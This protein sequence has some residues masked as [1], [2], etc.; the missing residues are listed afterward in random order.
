MVMVGNAGIKQVS[1]GGRRKGP[2][3]MCSLVYVD[4][5]AIPTIIDKMIEPHY[6][7]P[8]LTGI[9]DLA[10]VTRGRGSKVGF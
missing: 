7:R 4:P 6:T 3:F 2:E 9:R 5:S 10:C 1:L 8:F